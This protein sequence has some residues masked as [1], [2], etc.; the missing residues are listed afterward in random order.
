MKIAVVNSDARMQQVYINLAKTYDTYLINTFTNMDKLTIPD[1]LILPIKGMDTNGNIKT[2]QGTITF[3][4]NFY[5]SLDHT[6]I[7]AGI[8][9]PFLDQLDKEVNYYL[10]DE[11]ITQKNAILTAE[12]VLYLLIDHT[13]CSIF[14]CTIDVIGYGYCGKAIGKLLKG[15]GVKFRVVRRVV[16]EYN[17][18]EISIED[19]KNS[20]CGDVIINTAPANIIDR[21]QF[22]NFN[23]KPL[24]LDI[25][26]GEYIDH[27]LALLNN[28]TLIKAR[29]L[30]AVFAPE[31]AG[32]LIGDYIR[33]RLKNEE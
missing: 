5:E 25:A 24:I 12:G 20:T 13:K 26:S 15:L 33:E 7:F 27:K 14:D 30:P 4:E 23:P 32:N 18:N 10:Q 28:I 2:S 31:S 17:E 19:W 8:K 11:H 1:V 6:K 29:S 22:M 21:T 9:N 3:P 16:D